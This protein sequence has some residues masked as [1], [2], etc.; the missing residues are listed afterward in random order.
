MHI[1]IDAY[2]FQ[3]I[4]AALAIVI[5]FSRNR[6]IDF[7]PLV[8]VGTW[9]IGV[10]AIYYKYGSNQV[11]FY[12]NDQDIHLRFIR[13]Y[14][15][16]EGF[17]IR[18]II[19]LRY[20]ITYP[21]Y[22]LTKLGLNDVLIL[23]TFQILS[24]IGIYTKSKKVLLLHISKIKV[25]HFMFVASPLMFFFS[26]LALRDLTLALFAICF[27]FDKGVQRKGFYAVLIFLLKP[28]LSIAL[29]FGTLMLIGF[30][31]MKSQL[32][33]ILAMLFICLS[34]V[35]GSFSYSI[36]TYF[37]DYFFPGIPDQL[38]SQS[39]FFRISL[40]FSGL[41][42]FTLI[43]DKNSVVAESTGFLLLA[44]IV[45]FDTFLIPITFAVVC[46]FFLRQLRGSA[47]VILASFV[48]YLGLVSQ[49][50]FNS[51]RQNVPFLAVMGIVAVVNIEAVKSSRRR[52]LLLQP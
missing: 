7:F 35:F 33:H 42:F 52:N 20:L 8:A 32:N 12:S 15:P 26:L 40:N 13:F 29:V 3:A 21:A 16:E 22:V 51:T 49:T 4:G 24:L 44:R 41:Q 27:V 17:D 5:M 28:H 34:Y 11:N 31:R 50:E 23:K 9:L 36:G 47:F 2:Y 25:W 39:K 48:F 10:C 18:N 46:V 6:K 45:L 30:K 1:A 43:N 38:F 14:I 19:S 37:K